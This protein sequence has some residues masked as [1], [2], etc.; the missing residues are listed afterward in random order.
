MEKEGLLRGLNF[1]KDN[2]FTVK[3]LVTDRHKQIAAWLRNEWPD[4]MHRYD[5]WHLA[6]CESKVSNWLIS[7]L[8]ILF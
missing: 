6:K 5:V 7:M 8:L 3:M 2:D 4:I 1:L